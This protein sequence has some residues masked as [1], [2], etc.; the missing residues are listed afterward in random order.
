MDPIAFSQEL[1]RCPSVTPE[2]AG[3][4]DLVHNALEALGFTCHRLPYGD[5]DNLYARLGTQS[6]NI[7]FAGHTDVVP[8]GDAKSWSVNP[9]DAVIQD[10]TLIGR[11]A[12][13]M[14][15][16]IACWISAIEQYLQQHDKPAGSISLLITGDEEAEAINGTVKVIQWMQEQGE[17]I[18]ACIVGEPTNPTALGQMV[19]IGRRGSMSFALTVNG[20]QGHVAYPDAADNPATKLVAILHSLT[21]AVLDDGYEAFQPSNL[22][23]TSIT[24]DNPA[25]NVIAAHASTQFNVRFNPN[26]TRKSIIQWAVN[27]IEAVT[28]AYQLDNATGS[29]AF[30]TRAGRLSDNVVAAVHEVTGMTPEL[31]TTGG[32]S[33]ARF[34]KDICPEIVECG[35]INQTAH[36][37]DEKIAVDDIT[38]LRDI[39]YGV[40]ARYFEIL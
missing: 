14:K 31:S 6:P 29:E 19:K 23:V 35:L 2:D 36:Q 18:D 5:V 27:Q 3:A 26:H 33:D 40:L 37:V 28:D 11:G 21:T 16:A 17:V 32:T 30:L 13:D 10:G 25:T 15:P 38:R 22:E 9:F 7:C 8:V 39:Y 34:I 12:V 4:L 1:I 24:I 20:T